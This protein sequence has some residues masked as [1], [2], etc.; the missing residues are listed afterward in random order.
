MIPAWSFRRFT[1]DAIDLDKM[2]CRRL[3]GA[4]NIV[5]AYGLPGKEVHELHVE[6]T[7]DIVMESFGFVSQVV[8]GFF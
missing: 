1:D 3:S 7:L 5:V 8:I 6:R 2:S 4:I